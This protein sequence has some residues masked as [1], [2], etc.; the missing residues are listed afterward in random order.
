MM[1]AQEVRQRCAVN[2]M[3]CRWSQGEWRISFPEDG[4]RA[5]KT[6]YY[7]DDNDDAAITAG[8]MRRQRMM[9]HG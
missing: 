8:A 5:E 4:S 9:S 7:T 3:A 6:A 2:R 1:N